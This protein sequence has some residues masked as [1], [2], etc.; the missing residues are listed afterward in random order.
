MPIYAIPTTAV[1][2]L[3]KITSSFDDCNFFQTG[4]HDVS[5]AIDEKF[6]H[7]PKVAAPRDIQ[8]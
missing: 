8:L 3:Y 5:Q 2:I 4:V 7:D 6:E 1:A